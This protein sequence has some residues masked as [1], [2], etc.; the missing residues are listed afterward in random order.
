MN[1]ERIHESDNE[2]Q[3][4]D[5][6]VFDYQHPMPYNAAYPPSFKGFA[7]SIQANNEVLSYAY[8]P[9]PG[10]NAIPLAPTPF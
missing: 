3:F 9:Q 5:R 1:E 6:G 10:S 8:S 7:W 4:W 2:A